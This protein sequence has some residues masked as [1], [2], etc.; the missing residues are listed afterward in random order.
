ML[1]DIYSGFERGEAEL[2]KAEEA[3][4]KSVEVGTE[5]GSALIDKFWKIHRLL[6][7]SKKRG[8]KTVDPRQAIDVAKYT[9]AQMEGYELECNKILKELEKAGVTE[10]DM[11]A[12]LLIQR[13]L[14]GKGEGGKKAI[15]IVG[16]R[17]GAEKGLEA[18]KNRMGEKKMA[19]LEKARK[20]WRKVR[21]DWVLNSIA[22]TG[23]Y[24]K[25][26]TDFF[27]S[28]RVVCSI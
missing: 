16:D 26:F 1:E 3:R 10:L 6:A 8:L 19:V 17:A 24:D 13:G 15:P 9:E 18:L 14:K 11:G 5:A 28:Q 4:K 22:N 27:T 12:Y 23:I 21:E 20:Q 2:R 25:D 7:A